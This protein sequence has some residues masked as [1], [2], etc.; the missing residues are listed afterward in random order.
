M[1]HPVGF[2]NKMIDN[3]LY[4][5]KKYLEAGEINPRD[6]HDFDPLWIEVKKERQ[7]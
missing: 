7:Y 4:N 1:Y 5:V 3:A 6:N 2:F